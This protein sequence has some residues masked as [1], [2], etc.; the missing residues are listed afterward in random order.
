MV[1]I[2]NNYYILTKLLLAPPILN[3]SALARWGTLM[4]LL[5][6]FIIPWQNYGPNK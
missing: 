1:V 3:T 2:N 5:T 4:G 6:D